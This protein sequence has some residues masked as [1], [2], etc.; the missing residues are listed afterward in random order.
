M[1]K[2]YRK[3]KTDKHKTKC[4]NLCS[5]IYHYLHQE[6]KCYLFFKYLESIMP[7]MIRQNFAPAVKLTLGDYT[8]AI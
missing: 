3:G 4:K 7:Q 2:L 8:Y 5:T 1:F 6:K